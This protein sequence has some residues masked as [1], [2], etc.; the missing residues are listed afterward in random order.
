MREKLQVPDGWC[1]RFEGEGVDI[2]LGQ[3]RGAGLSLA[4]VTL[5]ILVTRSS[6]LT[7]GPT[8][9][10]VVPSANSLVRVVLENVITVEEVCTGALITVA[11]YVP[12]FPPVSAVVAAVVLMNAKTCSYT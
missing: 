6:A 8:I 12:M 10:C 5:Y 3:L 7:N 1:V 2:D 4:L 9:V 11:K